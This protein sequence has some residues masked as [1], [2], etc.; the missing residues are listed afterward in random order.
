VHSSEVSAERV[1][2]RVA[3]KEL[4]KHMH[5]AKKR[6]TEKPTA[7]RVCGSQCFNCTPGSPIH[8]PTPVEHFVHPEPAI[9]VLPVFNCAIEVSTPGPIVLRKRHEEE[10]AYLAWSPYPSPSCSSLSSRRQ[11]IASDETDIMPSS[12]K[13][14]RRLTPKKKKAS[15]KALTK[16]FTYFPL[17]I[18]R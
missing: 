9:A 5:K 8:D 12:P 10:V 14:P 6:I 15:R 3:E 2:L 11:S 7:E 16:S 1:R 18:D 4:D 17:S 13:K